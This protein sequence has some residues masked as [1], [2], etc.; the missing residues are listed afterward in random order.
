M[1][2]FT[3][4]V[5]FGPAYLDT[6]IKVSGPVAPQLTVTLD[7]SLP[8]KSIT[9]DNSQQIKILS[10]TGDCLAIDLPSNAPCSGAVYNLHEAI[11]SRSCGTN[12]SPLIGTFP[13]EDCFQQL[14]GMR[15]GYA[16]AVDG[17]LRMPLGNDALG[18][19]VSAMLSGHG[20]A[21]SPAKL[22]G[23]NSDATL[24]I[25]S[26]TGDKLAIGMRDAL[27]NWQPDE[28]DYI[29]A[30]EAKYIIFCGA[31]NKFMA[32][33]LSRDIT[34][35][36]MCAP[37]MRNID[38]SVY[39]LADL[40]AMIDY[41]AMNALE[42][43]HLH[44]REKIINTIPL[45]SITDGPRGCDI[46]LRGKAYFF[47]ALPH[48]GPVDTNRAGETYA[49]TIWKAILQNYPKFPNAEI[50]EELLNQAAALASRQAY[51]QLDITTFAFP[52]GD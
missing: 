16:M 17:L 51:R 20:I 26:N 14:G 29:L 32:N 28:I 19:S 9:P 25:Q 4:S 47:P 48:P 50:S 52:T 46:Y 33:I 12:A 5:I 15:A 7:Q 11:L 23:H 43:N 35:P 34:A 10:E 3:K 13:T 36:V 44:R 21:S 45:I 1:T 31:P 30:T 27:L 6:V 49:S 2:D 39:P 40:A 22:S 42:W 8:V 38:D 41:L 37:S 18:D 24:L